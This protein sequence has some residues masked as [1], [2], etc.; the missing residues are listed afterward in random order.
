MPPPCP[1]CVPLQAKLI[2]DQPGPDGTGL[3][4]SQEAITLPSGDSPLPPFSREENRI[5]REQFTGGNAWEQHN[6]TE[7][8]GSQLRE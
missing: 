6:E 2:P 1:Q 8:E 7:R 5:G 3:R 4:P